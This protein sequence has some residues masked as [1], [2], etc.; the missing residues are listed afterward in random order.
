MKP[1]LA[2]GL[3]GTELPYGPSAGLVLFSLARNNS[4]AKELVWQFDL[5]QA[6]G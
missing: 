5:E 4:H 6:S 3:F 2:A 1:A